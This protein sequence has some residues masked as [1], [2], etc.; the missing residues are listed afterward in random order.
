MENKKL[1]KLS[2]AA[3]V[4]SALPLATF[5]P[6]LLKITLSEGVRSIWAGAN[7]VFVLVA[8]C[9]SVICVRSSESRSAVNIISTAISVFWVLMIVGIVVLALFLN[10]LQ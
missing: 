2:V 4:V 3:L 5:L 6:T 8:L 10:F 1:Q 9:L 7:I